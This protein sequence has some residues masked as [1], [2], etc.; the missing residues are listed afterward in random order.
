MRIQN[1]NCLCAP[2]GIWVCEVYLCAMRLRCGSWGKVIAMIFFGL[3]GI[4]R[5]SATFGN[6]KQEIT[7]IFSTD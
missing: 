7:T 6:F 3:S 1:K 4:S 5:K 2:I